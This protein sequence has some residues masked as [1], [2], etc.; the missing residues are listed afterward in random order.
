MATSPLPAATTAR[1]SPSPA[2]QHRHRQRIQQLRHRRPRRQQQGHRQFGQLHCA[3]HGWRG[4][5][6][7]LGR[8]SGAGAGRMRR[9]GV[10]AVCPDQRAVKAVHPSGLSLR[11]TATG[12]SRHRRHGSG[13]SKARLVITAVVVQG[14]P[15]AQVAAE[16]GVDRSWLPAGGPV[17]FRGEA[18]F[19]PRF[20]RPR[21]SPTAIPAHVVDAV[22]AERDRLTRSGHDAGP[23]TITWHLAGAR[24]RGLAGVGGP[25]LSWHGRWS[26]SRRRDPGAPTSGSRPINPT[27]P[28]SPTSPTS[29]SV[30]APG[31]R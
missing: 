27:R 16:Y 9:P 15:M 11:T 3:R 21:S 30:R 24:D 26:R 25:D 23:Q 10:A 17:P 29:P 28:G 6:Q 22:L 20:R 4:H 13:L 18:A 5:G 14:R 2:T 12:V 7:L 8:M 31:W 1:P 19:E